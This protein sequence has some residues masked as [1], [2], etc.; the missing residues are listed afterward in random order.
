[1]L[2]VQRQFSTINIADP[3]QDVHNERRHG[4]ELPRYRIAEEL[5]PARTVG[6]SVLELGGGI[7]ELS[8]RLQKRGM[9]VTFV[10]LS[11]SNIRRAKTLGFVAHKLDL[12]CGLPIFNNEQFDGVVMLE[13]IEHVVAVEFLLSEVSRVLKPGGFVILSTP[14]F[15]FFLNRFRVLMGKLSHDEGYHYRFFTPSVLAGRLQAVGLSIDRTAH[16]M[17]AFGINY[18]LNRLLKQ[19][20]RHIRIP[21]LFAS[22][23][24]LTL[25]VRAHKI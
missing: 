23:L 5:L 2:E 22:P 6:L 20:R 12:N 11:E 7:A 4:L 10:D 3:R 8:R 24:A 25:I 1:M 14:N 16:S 9:K 18:V 15:A 13:I 19:P 17:P 21:R